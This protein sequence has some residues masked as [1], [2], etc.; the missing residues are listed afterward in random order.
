MFVKNQLWQNA[1]RQNLGMI[2]Q[3]NKTRGRSTASRRAC[4]VVV[5]FGTAQGLFETIWGRFYIIRDYL[6]ALMSLTLHNHVC[7]SAVLRLPEFHP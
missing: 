6:E 4:S 5:L 3:Q 7:N 2:F 1:C